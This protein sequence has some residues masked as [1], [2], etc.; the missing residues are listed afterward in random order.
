MNLLGIGVMVAGILFRINTLLVILVSGVVTCLIS[1]MAPFSI[2][3][4]IGR[5][6]VANRFMAL[7]V[8]IMPVIGI[9]ERHGLREKAEELILKARHATAGRIFFLYMA[10]RQAAA[11]LGL[12][13][14][15]QLSF[16]WPIVSPMAEAAAS[17]GKIPDRMLQ[18]RVRSMAAASENFGNSY[19]NLVF[20]AGGGLLL[21]RSV[22]QGSGYEADLVKMAL[23]AIPSGVAALILCGLYFFLF[24]VWIRRKTEEDGR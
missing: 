24:D 5:A 15:G 13:M 4:A 8:L 23:Y 19:G 2:L 12:Q 1:G 9:L 21:I 6:F 14:D 7:F 3:E 18:D 10:F 22:L 16:V 20:V 11:A 17:R